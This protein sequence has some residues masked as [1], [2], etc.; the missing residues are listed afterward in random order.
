MQ[1]FID[2]KIIPNGSGKKAINRLQPLLLI[3]HQRTINATPS[4][5]DA[6][7]HGPTREFPLDSQLY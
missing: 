4:D 5:K 3:L 1:C 7:I 6:V 2:A